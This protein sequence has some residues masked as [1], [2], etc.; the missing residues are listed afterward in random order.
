[1]CY[2]V[3]LSDSVTLKFIKGIK[4]VYLGVLGN[5]VD[6]MYDFLTGILLNA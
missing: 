5:T 6:A 1:M 2:D 4:W 3:L